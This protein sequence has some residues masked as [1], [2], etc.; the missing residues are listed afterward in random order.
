[1]QKC[2]FLKISQ[3]LNPSIAYSLFTLRLCLS[4]P[5]R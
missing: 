3:S 5:L 1:M 2:Y 4:A